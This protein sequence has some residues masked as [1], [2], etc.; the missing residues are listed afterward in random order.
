MSK[1]VRIPGD[2]SKPQEVYKQKILGNTDLEVHI[3]N[4]HALIVYI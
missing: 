1:D 4:E 3:P 2:F